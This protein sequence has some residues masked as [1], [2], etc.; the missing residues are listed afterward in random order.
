MTDVFLLRKEQQ[1]NG[2][3]EIASTSKENLS[4]TME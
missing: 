2:S 1:E 4:D 3:E